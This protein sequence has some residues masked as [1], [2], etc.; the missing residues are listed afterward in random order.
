M[1]TGP[2]NEDV[3]DALAERIRAAAAAGE[4]L[5]IRGG[6]SKAFLGRPVD[7][8][9]LDLRECRGIVSYEPS[10]LVI[11][12]RAG[13]PLSE[14][15]AALAAE[16]QMLPFEPPRLGADG[17][18]G[19]AVAAGLSGP[20]RPFRGAVRDYV[21]GCRVL[22]G[23]GRTLAF[24]GQV[25]KNVAGYD[26]SRLLAGSMGCLAVLVEVSLKVLP[27]PAASATLA[28][29]CGEAEAIRTMCRLAGEPLPLSAASHADGIL[30]LRLSGAAGAVAAAEQS[31][32]QSIGAE[33][34]AGSHWDDLR[35]QRTGIFSS[36]LPLWRLSVPA[37]APP[38]ELPGRGLVDWAGAQRWAA[39]EAD[40]ATVRTAA[41]AAGGHATRYRGGDAAVPPFHPL[42]DALLTLHR[43]IKAALDPAGI[44]NP[45][46]MY[47]AL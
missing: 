20:A 23:R 11:T 44:F 31:L 46:R 17:T 25:M 30:R 8:A 1:G 47:E 12:V 26:V 36:A 3:V 21:L 2:T 14:V 45:G 19:G 37:A 24:G 13:T 34:A 5:A 10:E 29:E 39:T 42:P 27:T 7:G 6:G 4:P 15:E 40:A 35:D 32:G 33:E 43:R 22:D 38:L 41:T 9:E 28:C 16:G 18:I